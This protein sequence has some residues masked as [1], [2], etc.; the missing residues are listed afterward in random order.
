MGEGLAITVIL[1]YYDMYQQLCFSNLN[2]SNLHDVCNGR[3]LIN[4]IILL[5]IMKALNFLR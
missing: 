3:A 2:D 1:I 4:F 5:S